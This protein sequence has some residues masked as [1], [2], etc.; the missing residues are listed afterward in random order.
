MT[1]LQLLSV[2][3]SVCPL[4]GYV[5]LECKLELSQKGGF[6]GYTGVIVTLI[7]NMILSTTYDV[8]VL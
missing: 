1:K 2:C 3:L 5:H 6:H 8:Y 4:L 7:L